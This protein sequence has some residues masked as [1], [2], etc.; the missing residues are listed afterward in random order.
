MSEVEGILA[1]ISGYLERI[2]RAQEGFLKIAEETHTAKMKMSDQ[3]TQHFKA[4]FIQSK[5]KKHEG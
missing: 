3:L 1:E 2:A 4:G 5:E